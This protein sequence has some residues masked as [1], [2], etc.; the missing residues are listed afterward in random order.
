[1]NRSTTRSILICGVLSLIMLSG[2]YEND[3]SA[4][5][6]EPN[7]SDQPAVLRLSGPMDLDRLVLDRGPDANPTDELYITD[8]RI[9]ELRFKY[10]VPS[11]ITLCGFSNIQTLDFRDAPENTTVILRYQYLTEIASLTIPE[12]EYVTRIEVRHCSDLQAFRL[13]G[14][15]PN[16]E[17][18]H[19]EDVE[20]LAYLAAPYQGDAPKLLFPTETN[21]LDDLP[22]LRLLKIPGTSIQC[23]SFLYEESGVLHRSL[24][25]IDI[26]DTTVN[27][28]AF[29]RLRSIPSLRVVRVGECPNLSRDA[30]S[31]FRLARPDV[32]VDEESVHRPGL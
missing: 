8:C 28:E 5:A 20:N 13:D 27:A 3:R 24:R 15:Y 6:D 26:R 25:E 10:W 2:S 23:G 4:R 21:W 32:N 18:I 14:F 7:G 29:A 16:L 19:F 9:E 1:M 30:I 11:V 22:S 31:D 17:S 12:S